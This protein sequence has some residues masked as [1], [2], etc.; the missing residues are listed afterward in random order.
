[1]TRVF[2]NGIQGIATNDVRV[3][4]EVLYNKTEH[5]ERISEAMRMTC[6]RQSRG[7]T[8]VELLVVIAIVGILVG[9]LLPAIQATR[10][11]TRR[12]QCQSSERQMGLAVLD[13][14]SH[15][16]VF[17]ASGWTHAGPGNPHGKY[18]S[19]RTVILPHLEQSNVHA[20]YAPTMHWWEGTNVAVASVPIPIYLCASVPTQP[21]VM[22]AISKPPR[23]AMVFAPP[24]GRS[25][26]EAIQ[27]VQPSSIDPIQYDTNNRFSVMHRNSRNKF[28]SIWDGS[29]NTVMVVEC[30]A[31]PTVYRRG[32]QQLSLVNEQG[33]G[34]VD[35]ESAFSLDGASSDV[36]RE[37]C[38]A[39]YGCNV[40][41]NAKNDNEP[42]SFHAS[43]SN[44]LFADGHIQ[45][46][47][48]S[49]DIRVFAAMCTRAAAEAA[50]ITE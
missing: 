2:L 13:F 28:A 25:D 47:S 19:W 17:P 18:V 29:S 10:D 23:P 42:S 48:Q 31:R 40:A 34:W 38:R 30:G 3:N 49:I 43:G 4:L 39:D 1:M 12:V 41:M 16:N 14:E 27:G 32:R 6:W 35:S 26:Y 46:V 9:L 22:S 20:L 45:F 21:E 37:G 24:L 33:I 50:P 5:C 15:Q 44:C 36:S 11:A 8:L 7:F